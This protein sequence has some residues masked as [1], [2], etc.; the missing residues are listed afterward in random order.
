MPYYFDTTGKPNV[1]MRQAPDIAACDDIDTTVFPGGSGNDSDNSGFPNFSGTSC[2]APNAAAVAAL[3]L[4]ASHVS[5]QQ[6]LGVLK[7]SATDITQAPTEDT[8][9]PMAGNDNY[10]GAGLVNATQAFVALQSVVPA[11]P[12]SL[13]FT[14]PPSATPNPAGQG[15]TVTFSTVA[16]GDTQITYDWS[17]GDGGNG[18]GPTVTHAYAA[19]GDYTATVTISDPAGDFTSATTTVTVKAPLI[20]TGNDSD[21]DGISDSIELLAGT[22]PNDPNS[23]PTFDPNAAPATLNITRAMVKL[24]F[25]RSGSDSIQVMGTISLPDGVML[26]GQKVIVDVGG[27]EDAFTLSSKGKGIGTRGQFMLQA[28]AKQ[29][30]IAAQTAK[31]TLK[32]MRG[33]FTKTLGAAGFVNDDVTTTVDL[34]VQMLFNGGILA[35]SDSLSYKARA[36]R[37]G[38]GR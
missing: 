10:T 8:S 35:G 15:Q 33:D 19:A 13:V 9:E 6:L 25:L 36:D 20:G 11:G 34:K 17:F 32:F 27:V 2:A 16:T 7:T 28:R 14:S 24:S 37:S 3:L 1:V 31:F 23:K 12:G 26:N 30:V 18:S 29:G 4:Q 38:M 5:P 21:G 22:D